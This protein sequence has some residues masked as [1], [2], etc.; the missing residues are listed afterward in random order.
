MSE[1]SALIESVGEAA[2]E[3][4]HWRGVAAAASRG[5]QRWRDLY[6]ETATARADRVSAETAFW[7]AEA[8]RYRTAMFMWANTAREYAAELR[9]GNARE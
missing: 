3:A 6:M 5:C 2:A 1:H 8:E 9:E 7:Q 4:V